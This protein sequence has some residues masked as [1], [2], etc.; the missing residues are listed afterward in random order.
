KPHAVGTPEDSC[1]D[2]GF[3][4]SVL[5]DEGRPSVDVGAG[6]LSQA[7]AHTN[8]ER[9]GILDDPLRRI[10]RQSVSPRQRGHPARVQPVQ[11]AIGRGPYRPSPVLV[12][13]ANGAVSQTVLC[14]VRR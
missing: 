12:K 11:P 14:A 1:P 6:D 13:V 9:R 10:A 7:T 5:G 4:L 2:G 3:S 8:Q